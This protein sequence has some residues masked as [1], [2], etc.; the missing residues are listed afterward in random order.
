MGT[1][2]RGGSCMPQ[3]TRFG[4]SV[5]AMSAVG[6]LSLMS[7]SPDSP[8]ELSTRPLPD[9][10]AAKGSYESFGAAFFQNYCIRCHSVTLESDLERL[11]APQGIDFNTLQMAREFSRRIRLRAGELGDMPPQILLGPRP[12]EAERLQLVDWIDCGMLSDDE[13]SGG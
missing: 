10:G 2:M 9:C 7:C 13:L 3:S 11:D 12:T 8:L 6:V 4:R 5:A 1:S